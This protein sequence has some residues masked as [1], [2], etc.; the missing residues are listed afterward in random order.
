MEYTAHATSHAWNTFINIVNIN[1]NL[2]LNC[3]HVA[4]KQK[5]KKQKNAS[6]HVG[7][8][9]KM[10]CFISQNLNYRKQLEELTKLPDTS[11]SYRSNWQD[12]I[13]RKTCKA[14]KT[15]KITNKDKK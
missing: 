4:K 2:P 7:S 5:A 3:S 12:K 11:Q 14:Q 8:C 13:P 15:Q 9:I 10:C 6:E 1:T